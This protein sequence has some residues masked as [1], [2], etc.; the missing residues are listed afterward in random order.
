MTPRET[1]VYRH[2][3]RHV[4]RFGDV[5][6]S[7]AWLRS[8]THPDAPRIVHQTRNQWKLDPRGERK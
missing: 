1:R 6:R 7:V 2:A 5:V 8:L 4:R 3:L